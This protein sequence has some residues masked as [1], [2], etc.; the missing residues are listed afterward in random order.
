M[1]R[2]YIKLKLFFIYCK[3]LNKAKKYLTD[4]YGFQYNLLYEFYTVLNLVDIPDT[5]Q[6]QYGN[7]FAQVEIKKFIKLINDDLPKLDLTELVNVYEVKKLD[8]Y[9][10]GIAFGYS[11]ISNKKIIYSML[12]SILVFIITIVLLII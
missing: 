3:K 10:Y 4:K 7:A 8:E 9:N 12:I 5:V 11:L 6:Q 2:L 1:Y